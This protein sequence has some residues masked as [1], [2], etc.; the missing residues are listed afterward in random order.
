ME[1]MTVVE[2]AELFGVART[3]I[4]S[5]EIKNILKPAM[6]TPT[7]RKYYNREEVMKLYQSCFKEAE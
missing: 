7:G 5:W 4:Y 3:T 1:L 6:I 2:V